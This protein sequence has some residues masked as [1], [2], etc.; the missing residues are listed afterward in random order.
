METS[1][2][3]LMHMITITRADGEIERWH[4]QHDLSISDGNNI[5]S[6]GIDRQSLS[7][8]RYKSNGDVSFTQLMLAVTE[9][10]SGLLSVDL[11]TGMYN[12]A[13]VEIN[14]AM[15]DDPTNILSKFI[16]YVGDINILTER[17]V[18]L[19]VRSILSRS[20][21]EI[22]IEILQECPAIFG[23]SAGFF[24]C[25]IDLGPLTD[26]FT[27][28][29]VISGK[30]WDANFSTARDDDFYTFGK[31]T[32]ST[33]NLAGIT[34]D[35]RSFTSSNGRVKTWVVPP[36]LSPDYGDTGT[37]VA[38]CDKRYRTCVEFGNQL[39]YQGY[40]F[41]VGGSITKSSSGTTAQPSQTINNTTSGSES[42][43]V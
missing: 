43:T 8:I 31:V 27:V 11:I 18:Q 36:G 3:P 21:K 1:P 14:Y 29:N 23:D 7:D 42:S 37:I 25:C 12:D 6:R 41:I 10:T 24:K 20:Q 5:F 35:V 38:G 32:F 26:T 22:P 15:Y 28:S 30:V 19:E 9:D 39:N 16:G 17:V 2:T 4:D 34:L 40:P 33:G 13:K